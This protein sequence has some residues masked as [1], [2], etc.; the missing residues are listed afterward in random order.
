MTDLKD[1]IK[2]ANQNIKNH[3]QK[4]N[5]RSY[6]DF[7]LTKE[8]K[9]ILKKE[10]RQMI[11]I[12]IFL[13]LINIPMAVIVFPVISAGFFYEKGFEASYLSFK[14]FMFRVLFVLNVLFIIAAGLFLF[15]VINR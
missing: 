13:F 5:W 3:E 10:K 8:E 6:P 14:T 15:V 9:R 4:E 11:L 1:T 2:E 7:L 12:E